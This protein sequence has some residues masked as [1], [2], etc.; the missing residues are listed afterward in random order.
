MAVDYP[1]DIFLESGS[2]GRI[3]MGHDLDAEKLLADLSWS[4]G[5]APPGRQ[6]SVTQERFAFQP[7]VKWCSRHDGFGCDNEGEWH[8]HWFAARTGDPFTVVS[9]ARETG[10]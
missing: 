9:W 10:T 8:S 2:I 3:H 7:R 6:L 1:C 5:E 4:I